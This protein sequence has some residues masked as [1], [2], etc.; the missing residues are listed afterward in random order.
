M[1]GGEGQVYSFGKLG[2]QIE[3]LARMTIIQFHKPNAPPPTDH[4]TSEMRR[5]SVNAGGQAG[6]ARDKLN[7]RRPMLPPSGDILQSGATR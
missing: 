6:F 5:F 3:R 7:R 4:M 2:A 1:P